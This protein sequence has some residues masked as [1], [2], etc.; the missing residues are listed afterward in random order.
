MALVAAARQKHEGSEQHSNGVCSAVLAS[1]ARWRRWQ[2]G[3]G[4][5]AAV[6]KRQAAVGNSN[7]DS[8]GSDGNGGSGS[9]GD[10]NDRDGDNY[11]GSGGDGDNNCGDGDSDGSSSGNGNS[12]GS[13]NGGM[14]SSGRNGTVEQAK[15]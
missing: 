7:G 4:S 6:Q 3:G 5:M 10:S 8:N 2:S 12:N 14:L 1:A 13:D 9:N 15:R 11:C